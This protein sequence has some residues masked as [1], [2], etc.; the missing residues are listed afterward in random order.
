SEMADDITLTYDAVNRLTERRLPAVTYG[1]RN[2][3]IPA[4]QAPFQSRVPLGE[5]PPY[6]RYGKNEQGQ[7]VIPGDVATFEYDASGNQT[8][9][10]NNAARVHRSYYPNGLLRRDSLYVRA[11]GNC[12]SG[13]DPFACH[14]YGLELAYDRNGRRTE[15]KHPG[16]LAPVVGGV[17]KDRTVYAYHPQTGVLETVTDVLGNQFGYQFNLRDEL[18]ALTLPGGSAREAYGYD[19]AGNLTLHRAWSITGVLLRQTGLTYDARGKTLTTKNAQVARDTL[20]VAYSGL[21]QVV[22]SH[23][24]AHGG[25][26]R[27]RTSEVF[28][29]DALGNV[30]ER[31]TYTELQV[32]G[33]IAEGSTVSPRNHYEAGTGRLAKAVELFQSDTT[34]YDPAGNITFTGQ[35]LKH[36]DAFL[37]DRASYYAADGTLMAADYRTVANWTLDQGSKFKAVFEEY[38]YDALGRRV[39]VRA[40]RACTHPFFAMY[41]DSRAYGE[42]TLSTVRRTAWDGSQEL[43][44]IQMPAGNTTPA[45]TVENDTAPVQRAP[46]EGMDPNPFFGRVVYAHGLLIDQPL[47]QVR[48]A[49]ADAP[50]GKPWRSWQPFAI[51]PFWNARRQPDNFYFPVGG[52][53]HCPWADD[54]ARCVLLS[55][56]QAWSVFGSYARVGIP[57]YWHGTLTQDKRDKAGTFYRRNRQYD[58]QTGRFTQEDPIGLAGGLNLYGFANGDPVNYSDPFG[59][60]P[61]ED[62]K[63]G[64]W[65]RSP[66]RWLLGKLGVD[67]EAA[68]HIAQA[69]Y[70]MAM[71]AGASG[72]GGLT[73]GRAATRYH[74]RESPT[75][76]PADARR[77]QESGELW[78]R[79]NRGSDNPSVDAY[80]GP[81]PQGTRGIEF[82]T[83]VPPDKGTPPWR[84]RWTGPRPGVRVE[85]EYAKIPVC[86]TKNTQCP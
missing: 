35:V 39:L 51:V 45:D 81:L 33:Q 26:V 31:D 70:E 9:A 66:G 76:T 56:P 49:Y 15:L 82:T 24:T 48:V 78:G 4:T 58:P 47:S 69:G 1:P 55:A 80:V 20:M 16:Q 7:F 85:G 50:V 8:L 46:V 67:H 54:A 73:V 60:C 27:T 36:T 68:D 86:V 40:R 14:A 18:E 32:N 79:A 61:P 22:T 44:E 41:T 17:P 77:I 21:G 34:H 5:N 2:E 6:P 75:Q 11:V 38:R 62:D 42:C 30:S 84:A 37:R 63:G 64:P 3:G 25:D 29:L 28:A 72:T 52:G 65:C 57:A 19:G 12:P 71:A 13:S 74:R 83:T 23:L 59:L 43:W 53:T 10:D